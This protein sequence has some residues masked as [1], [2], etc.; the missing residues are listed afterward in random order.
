MPC[1]LRIS[2]TPLR[3]AV[4]RLSRELDDVKTSGSAQAASASIHKNGTERASRAF[5]SKYHTGQNEDDMKK[6]L[7]FAVTLLVSAG[8]AQIANAAEAQPFQITLPTGFGAFTT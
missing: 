3:M 4:R 2:A 1:S 6:T 8:L 5:S 7:V